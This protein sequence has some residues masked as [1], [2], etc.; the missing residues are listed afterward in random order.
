MM[1]KGGGQKQTDH[2]M[3]MNKKKTRE[4]VELMYN[5]S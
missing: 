4:N 3:T 2:D 1:N 5:H